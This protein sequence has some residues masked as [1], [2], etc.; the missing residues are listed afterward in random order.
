MSGEGDKKMNSNLINAANINQTFNSN[1]LAFQRPQTH[2]L[3]TPIAVETKETFI[4]LHECIEEVFALV[5]A[6]ASEKGLNLSCQ[7]DSTVPKTILSDLKGLKQVLL[8]ML[9]K[10][11]KVAHTGQVV[12]NVS[13]K[14]LDKGQYKIKF[15]IK[16]NGATATQHPVVKIFSGQPSVR[17]NNNN[18][19]WLSICKRL[20]EEMGGQLWVESDATEE[21]AFYFTIITKS[22]LT[23]PPPSFKAVQSNQVR[24]LKVA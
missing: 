16:D 13:S 7:I 4:A 8:N 3:A 6:K 9:S 18:D 22:A 14:K 11:I 20:V 5:A 23:P 24:F 2:K 12:I 21:S 1:I 19:L 15:A 10:A 17:E